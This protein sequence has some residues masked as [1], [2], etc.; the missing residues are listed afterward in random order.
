MVL[1][2]RDWPRRG[3]GRDR[4]EAAVS[5]PASSER[6]VRRWLILFVLY[7]IP[8]FVVIRPV[9][10]NDIWMNIRAGR[11]IVTHRA[12]PATDPF[13]SHGQGRPWVAYSW[14]FE[15]LV[16]GLDRWLGLAGIVF[17]RVVLS[18]A[19]L[20]S[21]HRL[22]AKR[23]HRFVVGTGLV[24]LAFIALI[25]LLNERTWL[26]TLLFGTLTLDAILDLRAGKD[27]WEVWLLPPLY[28]LWA[29][30]HIQFIYGL[31]LLGLGCAAPLVDR[32]L[33]CDSAARHAAAAGTRL[34]WKLVILTGACAGAS[35]LNAYQ[36]RLYGVVVA[37]A[38]ASETYNLVVELLASG[39]RLPW[40]WAMPAL[41]GMAAFA[42]GR[43][44]QRSAFEIILLAAAS[45]LALRA[46]RDVWVAVLAALAVMT[47]GCRAE[48]APEDRF[49]LTRGQVLAL[50]LT[51]VG[52]L[53]ALG[54]RRG[55]SQEHLEQEV[56]RHYP[57]RA[58]AVVEQRGYPGPLFNE[59]GWGSYLIWRL[60]RLQVS[61]DGR[62]DLHGPARI[63][64]N[65]ETV[66]GLRGWDRD[67]DLVAAR[68]VILSG[69]TALA[70]LLR[71][72]P[73]FD[74][75]HEDPV[76][77]VFVRRSGAK[78]NEHKP[79]PDPGPDPSSGEG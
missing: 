71:L 29:N 51:V 22:V 68:T 57:A 30:L 9:S 16:H 13:S 35:L 2:V 3:G 56:A 79:D 14:L 73:R 74:L 52:L 55:L 8:A 23:E 11:W 76:A 48:V 66:S 38:T 43:R 60:D 27:R 37:Y 78:P 31:L 6:T 45:I 10:D 18:Y 64:R 44:S 36:A 49:R 69:K 61:I 5:T 54:W 32:L 25:P 42:L 46:R 63:R 19:V 53:A 47:P 4:D 65:V 17:Y 62:A 1:R 33:R 15:V 39:F 77:A 50:A 12:V 34:W 7:A 24:G 20:L 59:Y 75:V 41:V 28:A 58:A 70:S 67:P 72:D 40:E 21:L 26:F